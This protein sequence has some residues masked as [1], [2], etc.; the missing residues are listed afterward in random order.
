MLSLASELSPPGRP[1][2]PPAGKKII[3]IQKD[4]R[5]GLKPKDQIV[6]A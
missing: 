3:C 4:R 5:F 6:A 1:E 2:I